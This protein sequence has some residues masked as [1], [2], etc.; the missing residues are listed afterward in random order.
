M[1]RRLNGRNRREDDKAL[2]VAPEALDDF[3]AHFDAPASDEAV[4]TYSG[5]LDA[6][7]AAPKDAA[8]QK[9]S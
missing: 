2:T 9:P 6:L 8:R 5:D 4:I 3:F 1:L 7:L